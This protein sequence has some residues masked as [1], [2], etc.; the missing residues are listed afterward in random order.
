M[1]ALK[2]FINR[3]RAG[4]NSDLGFI[5]LLGVLTIISFGIFVPFV[6]FYW[7]DWIWKFFSNAYSS[8]YL[9][10]QPID[11]P[12]AG[13]LH[14]V[15]NL[16]LGDH[17]ITWQIGNLFFRWASAVTFYW[18]L[19]KAM[20][21]K[22]EI[23]AALS[24]FFLIYPGFSEQFISIAFIHHLV[25][26][27][28]LWLSFV[29]MFTAFETPVVKKKYFLFGVSLVM[30]AAVM[31]TTEYFF[32]IELFRV[33]LLIY[34]LQSREGDNKFL[35]SIGDSLKLWW[36]F[37]IITVGL[38]FRRAAIDTSEGATY[39]VNFVTFF[40]NGFASGLKLLISK[41]FTGMYSSTVGVISQAF[42]F[43]EQETLG[44]IKT[45]GYY[46]LFVVII[47]LG[48]WWFGSL[49]TPKT[50]ISRRTGSELFFLG[51]LSLSVGGI[52]VWVSGM[53]YKPEFP[54]D[55]LGLLMMVGWAMILVGLSMAIIPKRLF[56][57][58]LYAMLLAFS[59]SS[60]FISGSAFVQS[61]EDQQEFWRQ[62]VVRVPALKSG[63]VVITSE[64]KPKFMSDLSYMMTLNWLYD[65]EP[66]EAG[67]DYGLFFGEDRTMFSANASGLPFAYHRRMISFESDLNNTLVFVYSQDNC[68]FVFD[69]E[70]ASTNPDS[71]HIDPQLIKYSDPNQIDLSVDH[72]NNWLDFFEPIQPDNWCYF[73]EL[74]SLALQRGNYAEVARIGDLAFQDNRTPRR[75]WERATFIEG[76]GFVER[77]D[78]AI[79]L[80]AEA[81][82]YNFRAEELLCATWDRL[83]DQAP[84][85]TGK[86]YALAQ[87]S[88]LL[89]C[90]S[91]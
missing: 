17:P 30:A 71:R 16:F 35:I 58:G 48:W 51:V 74:G 85:S 91:E 40:Q 3:L 43:P 77:W 78:E 53:Q 4:F 69:S 5:L 87:V 83:E 86:Q 72:F 9:L 1:N 44:R 39:S 84:D 8:D 11:R 61:W 31:L 20:P 50:E 79:A 73:Y 33:V 10:W 60:N 41:M 88:L 2:N 82:S 28:V 45:I 67:L 70:T 7:D 59:V 25:P 27:T 14:V 6:G 62:F 36:P 21:G 22:K 56:L 37:A 90:G 81:M 19:R 49:L 89:N 42:R 54:Q 23:A 32:G 29:A 13:T 68:L 46:S 76:Y 64:L 38:M 24:I 12:L 26:L 65:Q 55:R 52:P 34:Y 75:S 15:L 47:I 63:T 66:D 80:T 57:S 18:M